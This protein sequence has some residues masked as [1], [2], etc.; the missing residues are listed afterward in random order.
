MSCGSHPPKPDPDAMLEDPSNGDNTTLDVDSEAYEWSETPSPSEPIKRARGC[1]PPLMTRSKRTLSEAPHATSEAQDDPPKEVV[2]AAKRVRLNVPVQNPKP[3]ASGR[4]LVTASYQGAVVDKCRGVP[5]PAI[6]VASSEAPSEAAARFGPSPGTQ[7][8]LATSTPLPAQAPAAVSQAESQHV[9]MPSRSVSSLPGTQVIRS[10]ES[11]LYRE[12]LSFMAMRNASLTAVSGSIEVPS[13]EEYP[14]V[15]VEDVQDKPL[16]KHPARSSSLVKELTVP[17]P[18]VK[19]PASLK[20]RINSVA[21]RKAHGVPAA[22]KKVYLEDTEFNTLKVASLPEECE[23][24]NEDLQDPV[25]ADQYLELPNLKFVT[26]VSWSS[27]VGPGNVLLSSWADICPSL[28]D[29]EV[30][31]ALSF[32]QR[33]RYVNLARINPMALQAV[34]PTYVLD[35]MRYTISVG[36]TPAICVSTGMSVKSSLTTHSCVN[37]NNNSAP[38]LKYVTIRPH[39]YEA[40]RAIG[41]MGMVFHKD[42]IHAQID[43][44]A[45]TFGTKSVPKPKANSAA[46]GPS[47]KGVQ[48]PSSKLGTSLAPQSFSTALAH[49]DEVPIYDGRSTPFDF[50]VHIENLDRVLP[51]YKN[52]SD[53]EIIPG[54]FIIVGY[55]VSSYTHTK[56]V[57]AVAVSFNIQWVIVLGEP[58]CEAEE[59]KD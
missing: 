5:S 17:L 2:S 58:E 46:T 4:K 10:D 59:V 23:V 32:V 47:Y 54:S 40:E 45:I 35:Q 53:G 3:S 7:R 33:G 24:F 21:K 51:R 42:E 57:G 37:G 26:V 8:S 18:E 44:G 19:T 48:S 38:S 22:A 41:V 25:L 34:K 39:S 1:T 52:T 28:P 9:A 29:T 20:D 6:K 27:R 15:P 43:A 50:N 13:V 36:E 14:L 12:F 31:M 49:T 56:T 11:A 30:F 55:T 16:A